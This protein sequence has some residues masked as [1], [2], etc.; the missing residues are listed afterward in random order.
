MYVPTDLPGEMNLAL[1]DRWVEEGG[2]LREFSS[3][4]EGVF[5]GYYQKTYQKFHSFLLTD[6][7]RVIL[8]DADGFV[9]QNLDHLFLLQFPEGT[10]IAA[11]QGYWFENEG[12]GIREPDACPGNY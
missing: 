11:P 10:H 2:V 9:L 12:V 4:K 1:L 8:M 7:E 3:L 5:N 6:Y